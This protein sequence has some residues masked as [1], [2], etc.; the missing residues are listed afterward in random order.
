MIIT[1]DCKQILNGLSV[2]KLD[3]QYRHANIAKKS[4]IGE[5]GV[6]IVRENSIALVNANNTIAAQV[7]IPLLGVDI[8]GELMMMFNINKM[9][10]YIKNLNSDDASI[11]LGDSMFKLKGGITTVEMPASIEHP[12]LTFI[13]KLNTMEINHEQLPSFNNT[14]LEAQLVIDGKILSDAIKGC[15]TIGDATYQLTYANGEATLSSGA[16]PSLDTF[17]VDLPLI[18]HMGR[19][20]QVQFSAPI[21]KF[22]DGIMWAYIKDNAPVLF[23]GSDRR[24]V[25]APYIG[26]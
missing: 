16:Y 8:P 12:A 14:Q 9:V 7:T 17:T 15:S 10:K 13:T 2:I 20:S 5:T 21:D 1:V 23:V 19:D 22:C 25:M 24:L 26:R 4:S 3:G 18:A 6:L 11:E